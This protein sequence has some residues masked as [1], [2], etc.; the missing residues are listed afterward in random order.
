MIGV[1]G[2]RRS[3]VVL[4]GIKTQ[5]TRLSASKYHLIDSDNH[6][7]DRD[8]AGKEEKSGSRS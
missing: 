5:Q 2:T 8:F 1:K 3:V 7:A 6:M 4:R